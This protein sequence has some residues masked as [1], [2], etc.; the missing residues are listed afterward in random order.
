M[1]VT[2]S[3]NLGFNLYRLKGLKVNPFISFIPVKLNETLIAGQGTSAEPHFY[4]FT[5]H[6]KSGGK[7]IYILECISTAGITTDEFRTTLQWLL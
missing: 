2:E 7:Y 3:H 6:V 1:T 5:D 4:A